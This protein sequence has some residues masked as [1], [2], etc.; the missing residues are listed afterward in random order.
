MGHNG[1]DGGRIKASSPA[2]HFGR[3]VKKERTAR[4]WTVHDLARET[5]I[6]A[7][8]LSRIERGMVAPSERVAAAMD[9]TFKHR[10][11][12]FAEYRH[13]SQQ[14][15]P[16]GYRSWSDHE[17]VATTLRIWC[18]GTFHGL[19]QTEAY[20][21]A[22]L[23]TFPGASPEMIE[24]RVRARMERRQRVLDRDNPPSTWILVDEPALLRLVGSPQIMTEQLDHLLSVAARPDVTVQVVPTVAHAATASE[25]IVADGAVYCEHVGQGF[26]YTD[27]ETVSTMGRVLTTLQGEGYRV[28]ESIQLIGRIREIWAS[29]ESPLTAVLTEGR[30]SK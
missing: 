4:G 9:A 14:W 8:H 15:A 6:D 18:P 10:R 12:W 26:T 19:V 13:D 21:R 7:G 25:V 30:A 1:E 28:S 20:A 29:G 2:I 3:Q 16:P 27:D 22:L 17:N 11:G 5:G 24:A 23:A